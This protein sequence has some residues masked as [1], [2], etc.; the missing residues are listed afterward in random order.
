MK[1][2]KHNVESSRAVIKLLST[3]LCDGILHQCLLRQVTALNITVQSQLQAIT[4]VCSIRVSV[5][6]L[7]Y[8]MK[9]PNRCLDN[10]V[11]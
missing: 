9:R 5:L 6:G 4:C 2:Y 7:H 3:I 1:A 10:Q 8:L 11:P